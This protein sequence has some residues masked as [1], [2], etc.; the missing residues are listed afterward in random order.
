MV[1]L[2]DNEIGLVGFSEIKIFTV[3]IYIYV[4]IFSTNLSKAS[5]CLK[6]I[7]KQIYF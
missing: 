3:Y 2:G 4:Y 1:S 5:N 6:G 7:K